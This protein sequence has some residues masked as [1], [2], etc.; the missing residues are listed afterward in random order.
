MKRKLI[1]IA[2]VTALVM[3]SFV[4]ASLAY[5]QDQETVTNTFTMGDVD[6][7]IVEE[8]TD[9]GVT[10]D[11][12]SDLGT[13][14]GMSFDR[15]LPGV[16]MEK[17][18]FIKVK[19]TSVDSYIAAKVTVNNATNFIARTGSA[20]NLFAQMFD[21]GVAT[22]TKADATKK[23]LSADAV[24]Y[25]VTT[26]DGDVFLMVNVD[27]ALDII[28]YYFVYS[29]KQAP[30]ELTPLFTKVTI[31]TSLKQSDVPA[32][33]KITVKIDAYAMQGEGFPAPDTA[34][35]SDI[36]L[37]A[38]AEVGGITTPVSNDV[39]ATAV[40]TVADLTAAAANGGIITL[41]QNIELTAPIT[42]NKDTVIVG[43]GHSIITNQTISANANVTLKD[44]V[45]E[46]PT[47]AG[48][49][50]S[51]LYARNGSKEIVF[52]NCTFSNPQ[53]EVVQITSKD[54]EKL[55]ITNCVFNADD[56]HGIAETAYGSAADECIRYIHIQPAQTDNVSNVEIVITG[57]KFN[58]INKVKDSVAGI[59]YVE[60]NITI[61]NN[62]FNGW[63]ENDVDTEGNAAKLSVHWPENES[64]KKVALWTGT[65]QTYNIAPTTNP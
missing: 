16:E 24:G 57:N 29:A 13:G 12:G 20:W 42:L 15:V 39:K 1:S 22:A 55:S 3:V 33:K 61:G 2:L 45:Y 40:S 31:P 5:F 32:N 49:N 46:H 63:A 9:A 10:K 43:D 18:P 54:F 14:E 27:D 21:G 59:Y 17:A 60:G 37:A 4:G 28:E 65:I 58:N 8:V 35:F 19:D 44:L 51:I 23:F 47:N 64:L 53:W 26:A 38:L 62:V 11:V 56:I 50:A 36:S 30:K 52:D 7:A 6:I 48:E 25:T 34:E 41:N